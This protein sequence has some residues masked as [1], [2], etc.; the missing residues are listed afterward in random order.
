M[1][2]HKKKSYNITL[3]LIAKTAEPQNIILPQAAMLVI[4]CV[5]AV[6]KTPP[7]SKGNACGSMVATEILI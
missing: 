3:Y 1:L 4:F 6:P 2:I 5:A 7:F